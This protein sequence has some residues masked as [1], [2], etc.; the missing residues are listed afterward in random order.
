MLK[1]LYLI[2]SIVTVTFASAQSKEGYWDNI[3]TTNETINLRAGEKKVIK[4][5]DFP[6]GTT[7]VV[8]R[9]TILDDNQK[10]SSSLVSVLK[11]I[12][13]PTGISQGTAGAIFLASTISGDDKCKYAIFADANEAD[14]FLT[15]AKKDKACLIQ[16]TPINKE[17]R[18]LKS[19]SSECFN[20]KTQKS[21][22]FFKVSELWAPKLYLPW[23]DM[24][25]ISNR[26]RN[27]SNVN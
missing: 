16:D 21:D 8:F 25:K 9:I 26:S 3:R 1:K 18:I 22:N 15:T 10:L 20:S 24:Q 19:K 17:A 2:A 7:E 23:G 11:A 14:L 13:D 4:S 27:L 12:P 6:E 5:A